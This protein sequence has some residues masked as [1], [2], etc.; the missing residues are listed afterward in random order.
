MVP[1]Q[2][3]A[4]TRQESSVDTMQDAESHSLRGAIDA[5]A[6]HDFRTEFERLEPLATGSLDDPVSPS[7]LRLLLDDGIGEATTSTVTVR[8]S[9]R[10]DYNVHYSDD[11]DRHLRWD[12][13]PHDFTHP[14]GEAH[15]HPPPNASGDDDDVEASSIRVNELVLVARGVHT[16]WR[17]GYNSG[18]ADPLNDATNPP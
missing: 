2:T 10:N 15:Y 7:E 1:S 9:V 13:H 3:G 5:S 6:L 11:T 12:V 16:L 8:W 14:A 18:T 4:A 17:E